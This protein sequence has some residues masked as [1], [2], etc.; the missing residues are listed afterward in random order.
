MGENITKNA[1]FLLF[2]YDSV[3]ASLTYV[4]IVQIMMKNI[5]FDKGVFRINVIIIGVFFWIKMR[6]K[7]QK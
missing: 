5:P 7:I 4:T 2:A 6:S 3:F 1:V